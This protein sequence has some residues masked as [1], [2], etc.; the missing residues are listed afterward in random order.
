MTLIHASLTTT[1]PFA[2]ISSYSTAF[3]LKHALTLSQVTRLFVDAKYL[4][5]VIPVAQEI[6]F[7]LNRIFVGTGKA[8]GRRSINDLV[9][10]VRSKSLPFIGI[11]PAKKSTLAYLVFSSGTSGLP[12]GL[13]RCYLRRVSSYSFELPAVMI[14]HGNLIYSLAQAAV[15]GMTTLAVYTVCT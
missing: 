10:H 5:L 8:S 4:P 7:D 11:K 2:L 12:K 1:V 6:G 15:V 3:E 9:N 13:P 14:S